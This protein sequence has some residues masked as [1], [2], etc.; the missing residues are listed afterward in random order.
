LYLS[1][2]QQKKRIKREI[3]TPNKLT[4]ENLEPKLNRGLPRKKKKLNHFAPFDG[5]GGG[6]W[7]GV[8]WF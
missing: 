2:K 1:K 5:A 3:H 8:W 4:R 6:G 7:G